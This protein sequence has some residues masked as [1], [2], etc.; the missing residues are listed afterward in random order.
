MP[1]HN[2]KVQKWEDDVRSALSKHPKKEKPTITRSAL[3]TYAIA[4]IK[5]LR[6]A[7]VAGEPHLTEGIDHAEASLETI[8]DLNEAAS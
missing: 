4:Q 6:E 8:L 2:P 7:V 5:A 3:R 1:H